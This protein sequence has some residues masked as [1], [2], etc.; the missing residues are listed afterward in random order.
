[1]EMTAAVKDKVTGEKSS[2]TRDW[3]MTKKEFRVEL[4]R[5]GYTVIG[6]IFTEEDMSTRRG[7]LYWCHGVKI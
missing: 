5:N 1:M 3:D 6:R 4:N 7:R 2:I